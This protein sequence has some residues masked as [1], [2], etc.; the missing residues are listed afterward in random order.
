MNRCSHQR[1]RQLRDGRCTDSVANLF[2]KHRIFRRAGDFA[3]PVDR[4]GKVAVAV[5]LYRLLQRIG[6]HRKHIC[7][8]PF[9]R[10]RNIVDGS[11]C[12]L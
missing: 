5:A 1:P 7:S 11:H 10:I 2:E 4:S 9:Q 12:P 6:V 3:Q 8:D